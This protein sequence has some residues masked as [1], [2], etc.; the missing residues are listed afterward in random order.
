MHDLAMIYDGD[1][2]ASHVL[3]RHQMLRFG[4]DCRTRWQGRRRRCGMDAPAQDPK[5]Q[6]RQYS[7]HAIGP[8]FGLGGNSL[9]SM[10]STASA[11]YYRARTAVRISLDVGAA[12]GSIIHEPTPQ[13]MKR[14]NAEEDEEMAAP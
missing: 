13:G 10:R 14:N 11:T 6:R 7:T 5:R 3:R 9:A 12:N 8:M 1:G 4:V 2:H